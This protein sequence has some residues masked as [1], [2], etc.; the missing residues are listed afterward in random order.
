MGPEPADTV[1]PVAGR[2]AGALSP[3]AAQAAVAVPVARATVSAAP[4]AA[5]AMV[6]AKC[7]FTKPPQYRWSRVF[8][9]HT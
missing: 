1:P 7:R 6:A 4:A 5:R 9:D 3:V 2:F 8:G